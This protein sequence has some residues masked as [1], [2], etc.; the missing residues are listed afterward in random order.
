MA[1][2]ALIHLLRRAYHSFRM[3]NVAHAANWN[4]QER[5]QIEQADRLT[6]RQV[7]QGMVLAGGLALNP[8]GHSA[9][10]GNNR[11]IAPSPL[12]NTKLLVVGAGI[13]GLTVAYRLQQ[14]GVIADVVEASD[15][16]G[17]RLRSLSPSQTSPGVVELGGEFIDSRHG[18]VRA[19]AAELGLTMAD[20]R[21]ADTGLEPEV[22]YFG[23]QKISHDWVVA[24]FTPLAHRIALDL[25]KLERR[26]TNYHHPSPFAMQLDRLSLAEYLDQANIHPVLNDLIRVAY[27]TEYG[28]DADR[29]S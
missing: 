14:A 28:L 1:R 5:F 3:S 20:L 22:L 24:E 26:D 2:T 15:R 6:R 4:R 7:L 27:V 13:A 23:G 18:A 10:A 9:L 8:I 16:I 19:L 17:G 25:S 12:G 29:Q 11:S 21:L